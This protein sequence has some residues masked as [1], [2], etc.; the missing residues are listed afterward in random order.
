MIK[1]SLL[2]FEKILLTNPLMATVKLAR[3]KFVSKMLDKN[4][5]IIDVGCGGGLSTF[6]YSNFCSKALGIDNDSRRKKEWCSHKS[7]KLDFIHLDAKSLD[8][9]KFDANCI[10]NVDFIEHISKK[11]GINFI[12]DCKHYLENQTNKRNKMLIIG[13]PSYYSK[14]YRAKHNLK[15]HKYEYK[16]EELY[17]LCSKN[18]SRVLKFSMNDELVHTGFDKLGWFFFLI[19][20]L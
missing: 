16:P 18:F 10:I 3:F 13:T 14:K 11:E 17:N 7:K 2:T 12:K 20:I 5:R 9:I 15:H 1:D 6:Y 8:K 19:C 4:D